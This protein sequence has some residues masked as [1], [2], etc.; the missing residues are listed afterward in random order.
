M[1][2]KLKMI[3]VWLV[4]LS[5]FFSQCIL[6]FSIGETAATSQNSESASILSQTSAPIITP[7]VAQAVYRD[8]QTTTPM[9]TPTAAPSGIV[10]SVAATLVPSAAL[11]VS[12]KETPVVEQKTVTQAVYGDAAIS[13]PSNLR[14][15]SKTDSSVVLKWDLPED[16]KGISYYEIYEQSSVVGEVYSEAT[17]YVIADLKPYIKYSFTVKSK[18][19]SGNLSQ[20]SNTADVMLTMAPTHISA[21]TRIYEDKVYGDLFLDSGVLDLNG[22]KITVNGNLVHNNGTLNID[23][24]KLDVEGNYTMS[25]GMIGYLK[26]TNSEDYVLVKGN[27]FTQA[28]YS[29]EGYLTAGVMEVRGDFT[30]RYY[31]SCAGGKSFRPTGAHKVILSGSGL[32][33]ISFDSPESGFNTLE[34][35]NNSDQGI[36]FLTPL[37]AIK[38]IPNGC[39]ISFTNGDVLG[40]KLE[41]DETY[42]GDLYLAGDTLDLNGHK[43]IVK[44][45]LVQSG[46]VVYINNGQLT[47]TGDY[48]LQTAAKA[49]NGT[50][51][52]SYGNGCLKMVNDID[53]VKVGGSFVTQS[54]YSHNGLLTA[55]TL[56]VKGDFIQKRQ[57]AYDNFNASGTHK[58][59]LSGSAL[60]TISFDSPASN[61]SCFGLLEITNSSAAGVKFATKT[62]VSKEVKSTVTPL[63]DSKNLYLGSG[64]EINW[65]VWPYDIGFEENRTLKKDL[66]VQGDLYIS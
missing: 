27:F 57:S 24:G 43:L 10:N 58:V 26:M 40:W 5:L 20:D 4:I 50:V 37:N 48:R 32:Q 54:Q 33:T 53:Y 52:Y 31:D 11:Q 56:E 12:A 45:N 9:A 28:H 30:Q 47:V 6:S 3:L 41:Q 55:G 7:T 34:L 60:Q 62:V 66:N 25:Y 35:D 29:N 42:D 1:R 49:S 64:A 39:R 2:S 36:K 8:S 17:S 16:S 61:Y 51:T 38:F 46:G 44:G 21:D 22:H 15:E 19:L 13:A 59:V 65:D 18:D 14:I 23:F 63:T